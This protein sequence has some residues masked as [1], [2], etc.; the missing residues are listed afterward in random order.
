MYP[1][2]EGGIVLCLI[3]QKVIATDDCQVAGEISSS[4]DNV[5]RVAWSPLV[6]MENLSGVLDNTVDV[7]RK[8]VGYIGIGIAK[9]EISE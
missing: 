2:I 4:V 6:D 3:A 9:D 5:H 8:I 1:E 7:D